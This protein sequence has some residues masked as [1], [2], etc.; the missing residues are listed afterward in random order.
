MI[1]IIKIW[2]LEH[3]LMSSLSGGKLSWTVE[4]FIRVHHVE[5][6]D[7]GVT[8]S[9]EL[10]TRDDC[11][12]PGSTI[13]YECNVT[14]E[15]TTVYTGSAF[16]C[17]NTNNELLLFPHRYHTS[18]Q[19]FFRTCNVGAIVAET[20]SSTLND[21]SSSSTLSI[22]LNHNV[23]AMKEIKC[24]I[25]NGSAEWV[26]GSYHIPRFTGIFGKYDNTCKHHWRHFSLTEPP[27][28]PTN[29]TWEWTEG[30]S[31]ITFTWSPSDSN[32]S[33]IHYNIKECGCGTCPNYSTVASITCSNTSN[34]TLH[35][36]SISL[37]TVICG[38]ISGVWSNPVYLSMMGE[39]IAIQ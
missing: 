12:C 27:T 19:S 28:P 21:L 29:L 30:H 24:S 33:N 16:N 32:C 14:R 7:P 13:V 4:L 2:L 23:M 31:S 35:T 10:I 1:Q 18:N 22:T 6:I 17:P 20:K 9:F 11:V 15:G 39:G 25:D 34:G 3:T 37:Q 36:C 8:S 5:D 26:I 38:N